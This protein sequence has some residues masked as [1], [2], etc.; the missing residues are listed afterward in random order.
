MAEQGQP[1]SKGEKKLMYNYAA[2]FAGVILGALGGTML[3]GPHV[4][5]PVLTA[6]VGAAVGGIIG[7]SVPHLY[8]FTKAH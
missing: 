3:F 6:G 2:A 5:N 1:I 4:N 7:F 8:R